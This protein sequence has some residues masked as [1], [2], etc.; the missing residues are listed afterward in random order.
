[1][2]GRGKL[3]AALGLGIAF[4]LHSIGI[5]AGEDKWTMA[6]KRIVRLLP[7]AFAELPQ[8][9]S[10][11]LTEQGCTI[12][13]SYGNK[14]PH[15]VIRGH[16]QSAQQLDWAILCYSHGAT[17]LLI[18]WQ[19]DPNKEEVVSRSEDRDYLQGLGDD[20][21][22]YSHA[23]GVVGESYIHEHFEAYGGHELPAVIDHDGINDIFL[24][25]A[26]VVLYWDNGTWLELTGAD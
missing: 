16:F 6:E 25:K 5:V 1:M 23:I 10:F 18:F 8:T 24:E 14:S 7:S 22:G 3:L 2:K 13:Q 17:R 19:G 11:H 26:S 21:I 12:P 15:N 20:L 4:A 9:L